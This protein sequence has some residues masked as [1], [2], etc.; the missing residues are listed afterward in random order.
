MKAIKSIF[1]FGLLVSLG[2]SNPGEN[3]E[4]DT[5]RPEYFS[6]FKIGDVLSNQKVEIPN[7]IK[8]KY[9]SYELILE[10]YKGIHLVNNIFD[11]TSELF[12]D[13]PGI[14]EFS[15]TGEFLTFKMMKDLFTINISVEKKPVLI[16][17][18]TS[19]SIDINSLSPYKLQGSFEC[20]DP[21]KG[22]IKNWSMEDVFDPK[23]WK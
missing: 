5:R 23:C 1:F 22:Y 14:T 7:F 16:S 10:P 18:I 4:T 6:E 3:K 15:I 8:G 17:K 9:K 12:W 20:V 19:N 13:F 2:C 21:S 11:T